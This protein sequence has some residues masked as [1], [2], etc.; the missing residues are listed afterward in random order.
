MN[1]IWIKDEDILIR[2]AEIGDAKIL[3]AWWT[4]P[5]VMAHAGLPKGTGESLEE[6]RNKIENFKGYLCMIE[7][8]GKR[9]G[10]LSF[11]PER[12]G[13]DPGWKICDKSY[14]NKGYGPR[15]IKLV[16]D[17]IFKS[18]PEEDKITWDTL[19]DNT[20]AQYVYEKKIGAKRRA[21]LKDH[22]IDQEGRPRAVVEYEITRED[23]YARS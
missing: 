17:Y 1:K 9:V 6:T 21:L 13:F 16:L 14:Q 12:Q 8:G 5:E 19:E 4:D 20:R 22:Y 15:I 2:S 18:Y 11:H 3:N 7:I 10:E 23:F